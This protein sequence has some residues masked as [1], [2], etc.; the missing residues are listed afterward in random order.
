MAQYVWLVYAHERWE[1]E[2]VIEAHANLRDAKDAAK[3]YANEAEVHGGVNRIEV[4]K[5]EWK[6]GREPM[7][8]VYAMSTTD[9]GE[10]FQFMSVRRMVVHGAGAK[11]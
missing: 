1:Y 5:R 4:T 2:I 7:E 11:L 3:R 10:P 6:P 8:W 9:E